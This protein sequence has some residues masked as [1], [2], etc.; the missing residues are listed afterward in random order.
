[1]F[2]KGT[3]LHQAKEHDSFYLYEQERIFSESKQLLKDFSQ[4]KFLYSIRANPCK[5]IVKTFIEQG[6]GSDA[7][8]LEDVLISRKYGLKSNE[9]YFSAPGKTEHDIENSLGKC[10]IIADSLREIF[11]IDAIA[12]KKNIVAKIGV[13]I[14]PN[15]TFEGN[16]GIS[17]KF[18]IDETLFFVSTFKLNN[19]E[20][21]KI[22]GLYIH[23]HCPKLQYKV[24]NDYY[25]KIFLL[26]SKIQLLYERKFEFVNLG[27]G[28]SILYSDKNKSLYKSTL[29]ELTKQFIEHFKQKMPK[30]LILIEAGGYMVNQAGVYVTKVVD[31]KVSFGKTFIILANTLNGFSRPSFTFFMKR[32][33]DEKI[34][35]EETLYSL[36]NFFD[37]IALND[38]KEKEKVTLVGNRC[39]ADEI[40]AD[41]IILPVLKIGDI[42]VITNAGSYAAVLSPVQTSLPQVPKKF[43]LKS[44]G[45]VIEV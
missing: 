22:V 39:T 21:V 23:F 11:R 43:M 38:S 37:F 5:E 17:S 2:N 41:D 36:Y 29:Y 27:S 19:L 34:L 24:L 40:I 26:V 16:V 10:T 14:N 45:D 15:F 32:H 4:V 33:I 44:N 42:L 1:M 31:K 12:R 8:N 13:H 35:A 25:E 3:I 30:A 18:G 20:N 9:I 28:L 6:F 7:T